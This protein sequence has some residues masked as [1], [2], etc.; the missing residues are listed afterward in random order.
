MDKNELE[1]LVNDGCSIYDISNRLG[2]G[3]TTIRYWLRKHG[4]GT[5]KVHK[6]G[7]CG[8]TKPENFFVGRYTQCKKCRRTGQN[9]L[10]QK[11]K[12][13]LVEY[14]GGRCEICGYKKCL[15][16]LDFHHRNPN[17]KDPKWVK[18]RKW[19]PERVKK[20]VDKCQLLCRNCHSEIHYGNEQGVA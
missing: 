19:T 5:K 4:L 12:K 13:V 1:V 8:D 10:T 2:K 9:N 11:H 7:N 16:A 18:M 20:E 14:K 3:Y 17:E 6:C 15:A